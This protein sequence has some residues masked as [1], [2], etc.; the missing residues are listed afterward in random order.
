M[1]Y[2]HRNYFILLTASALT[3]VLWSLTYT[4]SRYRTRFSLMMEV[5]G[6]AETYGFVENIGLWP[7]IPGRNFNK[8]YF[9]VA[10]NVVHI[11][12]NIGMENHTC[13]QCSKIYI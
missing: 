11:Y 4:T 6:I 5:D 9:F 12:I 10:D 2:Y 3:T 1:K 8:N 7:N 13:L